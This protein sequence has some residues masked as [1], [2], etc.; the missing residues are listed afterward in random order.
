MTETVARQVTVATTA[1][2]RELGARLGRLCR[3]GDVVVLSGE[4]GAGKTTLTQGLAV[5]LG[6]DEAVT[7]P[8]FV[9]ARV[10]VHPSEGPDLVHVDAYRV[11]SAIELDDLDLDTDLESSVV[12]VEWGSGLAERLSATRLDV[13]IVRP[14]GEDDETRT[15]ILTPHGEYWTGALADEAWPS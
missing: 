12:V 4:L 6:I 5:G 14:Q 15:V 10:H 9:I 11:G 13:A 3:G 1:S 7:S 8:T 2:M